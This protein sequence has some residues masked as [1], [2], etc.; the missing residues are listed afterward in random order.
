MP[1]NPNIPVEYSPT[2][3]KHKQAPLTK[4]T[5]WLDNIKVELLDWSDPIKARKVGYSCQR[6]TWSSSLEE[7]L[8]DTNA[9][10]EDEIK[11]SI[12]DSS[13]G[14][15]LPL[16]L[17]MLN[18]SFLVG[19]V[20][21]ITTHQIVRT[22][23]GMT[24]SQRCSGDQ[25]VRHDEVLVPRDIAHDQECYEQFISQNLQFKKWYSEQADAGVEKGTHSIQ[26]LR[27]LAPHC[28]NQFIIV[29]GSLLA[30]MGV[31]G[32]RLCT[33]ETVEYNKVASEYQRLICEK[34]PECKELLKADCD[35]KGGCFHMRVHSPLHGNIY[36]PDPKHDYEYNDKN[37]VYPYTRAK[38]V[39]DYPS[40]KDKF[41][42]GNT[43]IEKQDYDNLLIAN[44]Q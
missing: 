33:E 39:E 18:F 19:G 28:L 2:R 9:K 32:K 6:A 25:D 16:N 29:S 30:F 15:S 34:F 1:N 3:V 40:V 11:Q 36:L 42:V 24:Y 21:R 4:F 22:R 13:K 44:K 43:E 31:I 5:D 10:T 35:K 37:F 14:I 23:I 17:E 20:S 41:Y 38:M 12:K 26:T 27:S 7:L 8:R